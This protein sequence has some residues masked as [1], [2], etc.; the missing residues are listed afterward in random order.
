MHASNVGLV[1]NLETKHVTPQFHVIFDDDFSSVIV[2]NLSLT[3]GGVTRLLQGP[4]LAYGDIFA[5]PSEHHLFE[6]PKRYPFPFARPATGHIY[7]PTTGFYGFSSI[8]QSETN[9]QT[10]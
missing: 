10:D 4:Q 7:G 1:Y 8:L 5:P 6:A 9:I 2:D 3:G